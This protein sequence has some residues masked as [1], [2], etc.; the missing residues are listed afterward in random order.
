MLDVNKSVGKTALITGAGRGIGR[1]T[2][3]L[4]AREGYD[5]VLM[6]RTAK[7]LVETASL[8][9]D[10]G[11]HVTVMSLALDLA[12][13]KQIDH[14]CAQIGER[15]ETVD[16]LV[17][18]AATFAFGL[19]SEFSLTDFHRVLE[20]NLIAPYYLS[21]KTVLSM[22]KRDGGAI[23]NVSSLSGCFGTAKFPGFRRLQHQ[24]IRALGTNRNSGTRELETQYPRQPDFAQWRR[25]ADV[26]RG[27]TSR[28]QTRFDSRTSCAGNPLSCYRRIRAAHR[29]ESDSR[30][31]N[32]A[33]A[34]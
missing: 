31:Q 15:C 34:V 22:S 18:N 23:V 11:R 13:R 4:F 8:C 24:Q 27:I 14:C 30:R 26:P 21:Q 1:A 3:M 17:N 32:Q 16:V 28:P 2:A 5:L 10:N 25:Y 29:Q 7:Q 9:K 20:V 12:D 19:V 33:V 6:A